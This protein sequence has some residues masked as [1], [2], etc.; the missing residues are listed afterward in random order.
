MPQLQ[1][2][3]KEAQ[4]ALAQLQRSQQR[5]ITT[6]EEQE[7]FRQAATAL[8]RILLSNPDALERVLSAHPK[9]KVLSDNADRLMA[10]TGGV[11]QM[12]Q[13][14]SQALLRQAQS[15][16]HGLAKDAGLPNDPAYL[17]HFV[18]LV[19]AEA[20][21]L[22]DGDRRFTS[23]DL[24]VFDE[25]FQALQSNFLTH[26]QRAGTQNL[27]ATKARTQA[28]P[29]APRGGTA[30]PPGLSKFDPSKPNAVRDRMAELSRAA[31]QMLAEGGS[32]E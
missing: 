19:A 29:P 25:A 6:P 7:Q 8:E 17:Q 23:G 14:Q 13:S 15:H 21:A 24:S 20:Q 31:G 32:K 9:F 2:Q 18:R 27:L 5:G 22:P 3:L 4:D 10:L 26:M 11:Q 28:L 1:Q 16:I 12:Q 30:G